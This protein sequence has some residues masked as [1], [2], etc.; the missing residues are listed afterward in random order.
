[1]AGSKRRRMKVRDKVFYT[2]V[3]GRISKKRKSCHFFGLAV[4]R[5]ILAANTPNTQPGSFPMAMPPDPPRLHLALFPYPC[6]APSNSPLLDA[7]SAH[8]C[9]TVSAHQKGGEEEIAISYFAL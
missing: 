6:R 3:T 7:L 5:M 2:S 9:P 1:M 8:G 4:M